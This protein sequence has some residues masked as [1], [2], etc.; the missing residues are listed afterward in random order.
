M[1]VELRRP[2]RLQLFIYFVNYYELHCI[3]SRRRHIAVINGAV[4]NVLYR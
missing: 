3:R 2:I 4:S 1:R